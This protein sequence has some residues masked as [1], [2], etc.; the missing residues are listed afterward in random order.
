MGQKAQFS[1]SNLILL[2]PVK[3]LFDIELNYLNK[4]RMISLKN[5][6]IYIAYTTT[7]GNKP[8]AQNIHMKQQIYTV[9]IYI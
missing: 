6:N 4:I 8:H 1:L 9:Y 7:K 2:N 5:S 3:L